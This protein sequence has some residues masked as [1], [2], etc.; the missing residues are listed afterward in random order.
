MRKANKHIS[1][2]LAKKGKFVPNSSFFA[3]LRDTF[4][5]NFRAKEFGNS[6]YF[7]DSDFSKKFL[8]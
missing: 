8:K 2:S 4:S 1:S 7:V 3:F 5:D 6:V